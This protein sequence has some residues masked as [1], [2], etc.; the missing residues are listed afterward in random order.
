MYKKKGNNAFKFLQSIVFINDICIYKM[1]RI[2]WGRKKRKRSYELIRSFGNVTD[3][4][5]ARESIIALGF[6]SRKNN[7]LS[8]LLPRF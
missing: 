3:Q 1:C 4:T 2:Q 7:R 6:L 8:L 5:G